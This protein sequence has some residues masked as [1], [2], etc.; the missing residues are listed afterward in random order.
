MP[1][2][3]DEVRDS[4]TPIKEHFGSQLATEKLEVPFASKVTEV[5]IV[6]REE[7]TQLEDVQVLHTSGHTDGSTCYLFHSPHGKTYLFTGDTFFLN[8]GA[9]STLVLPRSGGTNEALLAS[10]GRLRTLPRM[11]L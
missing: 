5:N 4:L 11:W 3:R 7:E 10:P 8:K 2:H 6:F 1:T 9:W